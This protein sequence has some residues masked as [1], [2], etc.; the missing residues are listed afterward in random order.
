MLSTDHVSQERHG[1]SGSRRKL[2]IPAQQLEEGLLLRYI[3][4][5][6]SVDAN[7]LGHTVFVSPF[8]A[9][10]WHPHIAAPRSTSNL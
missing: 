3:I 4:V 6:Q 5:L 2:R 10:L 1:Q 8:R 9:L 7:C